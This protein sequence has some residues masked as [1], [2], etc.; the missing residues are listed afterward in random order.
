MALKEKL[1]S[2]FMAFE[3][4]VNVDEQLHDIRNSAIKVF[5]EK[6]FPTKKEEAWKYTSLVSILK[7]DY[8]VFPK[9]EVSIGIADVKR[10]FID[11]TDTYKVVFVNGVFNSFLSSTTHD[12]IDVCLFSS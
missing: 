10:F 6:G 8:S 5:E 2:S 9:T 11:E 4:G 7:H 3:E 12:G 1:I